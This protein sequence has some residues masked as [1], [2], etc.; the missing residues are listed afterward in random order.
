MV[1]RLGFR[2]A[3]LLSSTVHIHLSPDG[4]ALENHGWLK[5]THGLYWD[6]NTIEQYASNGLNFIML[7]NMRTISVSCVPQQVPAESPL[8]VSPVPPAPARVN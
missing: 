3:E 5:G 2:G 6:G 8:A 1:S 7:T 4:P